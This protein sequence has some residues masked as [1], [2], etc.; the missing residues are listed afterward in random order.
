MT[1]EKGSESSWFKNVGKRPHAK[2]CG[3]LLED[4]RENKT[5]SIQEPPGRN[6]ALPTP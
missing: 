4:G 6:V 5:D 1:T 2:D 3:Q